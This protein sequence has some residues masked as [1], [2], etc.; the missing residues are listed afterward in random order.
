MILFFLRRVST[1]WSLQLQCCNKKERSCFAA[2]NLV[3]PS[4]KQ[5]RMFGV[6]EGHATGRSPK[7]QSTPLAEKK[8][9][10]VWSALLDVLNF[11]HLYRFLSLPNLA[12]RSPSPVSVY[13]LPKAIPLFSCLLLM[14][15]FQP[16]F[17]CGDQF[18]CLLS[19]FN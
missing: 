10:P 7:I 13:S 5:V 16:S 4:F 14:M 9:K 18:N 8:K 6:A 11:F 2:F 12:N 1:S 17:T 19:I 15:L 3:L